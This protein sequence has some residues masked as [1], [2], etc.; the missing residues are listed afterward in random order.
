MGRL[1][2]LDFDGT[3]TQQDTLNTLVS[4]AIAASD[5]QSPAPNPGPN[6]SSPTPATPTTTTTTP[7][8]TQ[9]QTQTQNQQHLTALWS[10]IVRDYVAAHE[11]HR[12]AYHTPAER[13]TTLGQEL[14]CLESVE[15]VERA[16]VG[17][18]GKGEGTEGM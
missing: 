6:P 13:R 1:L 10:E 16:S 4:L 17:R 2:L 14:A 8:Q 11:A 5:P 15:H 12:A 3:I 9:P 7:S 18:V